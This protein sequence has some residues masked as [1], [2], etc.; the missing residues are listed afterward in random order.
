M[1][2][3]GNYFSGLRILDHT[4]Y[5]LGG[6]TTQVFADLGAEIIKIEDTGSGDLCRTEEPL[7]NGVSHYFSALNRNKK[8]VTLNLKSPAA[9]DAYFRLVKTADVVIENFRPGVTKR[10]GIDYEAEKAVKPD[11]IHCGMS[12]FGQNDPRS[13]KALHDINF[14]ALSGY[15]ALNGG[16]ISP[17]HFVDVSTGMAAAQSVLA[18]LLQREHSGEG[19]FCDVKM[20]DSFVWWNS[21][22]DARYDFYGGDVSSETLDFPALSYNVYRTADGG[23]ISIAMLEEKFWVSFLQAVGREDLIPYKRCRRHEAAEA[24]AEMEKIFAGRTT[25]EWKTF[26]ADKD[27]CAMPIL[28]KKEAIEQIVSSDTGPISYLDF[29]G[30]GKTLQTRIP[31][32]VSTVPVCFEDSTACPAPGSHN[33]P[34][35]KSL[36]YT[37]EEVR[38]MADSGACGPLPG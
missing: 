18:A 19:A 9:K 29:P 20:F 28:S 16:R 26:L 15:L 36:G 12:S 21:L 14:Q 35:L 22:I 7:R 31:V 5:L 11:I 30:M 3:K 27:V 10:L 33:F 38:A 1:A 4:R 2:I 32:S 17:V 24:F 37:Y 34:I 25:E 8:S 13:L 23:G 6:Y